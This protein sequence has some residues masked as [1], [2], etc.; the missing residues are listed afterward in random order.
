VCLH[1]SLKMSVLNQERVRNAALK[2]AE[3]LRLKKLLQKLFIFFG[4]RVVG[5]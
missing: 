5:N 2:Q 1:L 3:K 4:H